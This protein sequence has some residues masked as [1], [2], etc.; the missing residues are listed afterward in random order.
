MPRRLYI[1][2]AAGDVCEVV[3]PGEWL[4]W[5][6]SHRGE[7]VIATAKLGGGIMV[8]TIF[9]GLDPEGGEPPLVYEA[10]VFGGPLSGT[11]ERWGTREAATRGHAALVARARR[12]ALG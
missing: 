2:S 3:E 4:A 7:R 9:A 8:S 12:A 11:V 1:E 5:M 6:E 10:R